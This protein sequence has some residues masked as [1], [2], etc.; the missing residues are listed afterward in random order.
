MKR[1]DAADYTVGVVGLGAMGQG[2]AQVSAQGGMRTI[3]IDAKPGA[4][5][6]ARETIAGRINRLVEKGRMAAEDAEAAIGLMHVA[7][8]AGELESA[9]AVVEAVFENLELKQKLFGEIEAVVSDDCIIASNTSSIP[10]ASI[11]RVCRKRD[12]V[13]GLHFFNP[14]PL[15]KLVEVIRAAETSDAVSDAL[16]EIGKRMTR[17][18]VVVQ[19]SP[20]FLVNMGG[21]AF[22]T[23][24]LRI[25]HEG[26]AT[27]SQI[28]A[29][30]RDCRQFRMGPFELMD[31]TGIDVNYPVNGIIYEGYTHDQRLRT[32]PNHRAKFDAGTFGGK[33][34]LAGTI[35]IRVSRLRGPHPI[36]RPML[37]LQRPSRLPT[38]MMRR[39]Y[40]SARRS[41]S[42]LDRTT[43]PRRC[44]PRRLAKMRRQLRSRGTS[45]TGGS[46]V[47]ISRAT[48]QSA[49][50]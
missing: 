41:G 15:M 26:V 27:P 43:A 39:C 20:G 21:R 33:P 36:T 6:A 25:A 10:I 3:L 8:S 22:T 40:R 28:D 23:E 9:D 32:W 14:V 24:G 5:E 2:I 31:L 35:M 1:V 47:W 50:P 4:A 37:R 45:T 38:T 16:V 7:D 44:L 42:R 18:P 46:C 30:M 13:A 11:A 19:D 48:R 49:L 29:I 34:A 17:T 12:R